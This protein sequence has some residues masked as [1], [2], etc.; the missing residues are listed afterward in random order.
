MG[1]GAFLAITLSYAAAGLRNVHLS[2][3]KA[4]RIA[5]DIDLHREKFVQYKCNL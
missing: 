5:P 1:L 4:I 2:A 3:E